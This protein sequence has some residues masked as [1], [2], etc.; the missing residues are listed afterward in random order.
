VQRLAAQGLQFDY[1]PI[2]GVEAG[3]LLV[4][5]EHGDHNAVERIGGSPQVIRSTAGTFESPLE[6]TLTVGGTALERAARP[7]AVYGA[8]LLDWRCGSRATG[9]VRQASNAT[10]SAIAETAV[11]N[12]SNVVCSPR[13]VTTMPAST[14]GTDSAA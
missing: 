13:C 12:V 8:N 10:M 1:P 3:L 5:H 6:V 4:T 7:A 9:R 14:A 2:D 11:P